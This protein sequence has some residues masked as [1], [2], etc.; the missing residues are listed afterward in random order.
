MVSGMVTGH[1]AIPSELTKKK[2][3]G[4]ERNEMFIF[5][6]RRRTGARDLYGRVG[7]GA[8][9]DSMVRK[10]GGLC[11]HNYEQSTVVT[12]L[13]RFFGAVTR[14]T[15]PQFNSTQHSENQNGHKELW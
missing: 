1:S 10:R 9:G 7:G 4:T 15:V 2:K 3:N 5:L 14:I 8:N 6:I 13:P 11:L 12:K